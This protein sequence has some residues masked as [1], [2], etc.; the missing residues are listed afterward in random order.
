MIGAGKLRRIGE[1]ARNHEARQRMKVGIVGGRDE[2]GRRNDAPC[3]MTHANERLG[4]ARHQRLRIDLG[5]VPELQPAVAERFIDIDGK[6][7][8][9][10]DRQEAL[11][12]CIE[13]ARAKRRTERRQHRQPRLLAE[14]MA[15]DQRLR[16]AAAEQHHGAAINLR[17]QGFQ[18]CLHFEAR[19]RA[20]RARSRSGRKSRSTVL[21]SEVP[22]SRAMKPSSSS[23]SA[24]NVR[25]YVLFSTTHARGGIGLRPNWMISQ[26]TFAAVIVARHGPVPPQNHT[27]QIAG[28][29]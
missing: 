14:F 16:A 7:R 23:I 25:T 20:A 9:W 11:E 17:L 28:R 12:V 15:A 5:L 8:W 2:I 24:R 4:A 10:P 6:R 19:R 21:I 27:T 26:P 3:G 29:I 13:V 1:R 22:A 18:K